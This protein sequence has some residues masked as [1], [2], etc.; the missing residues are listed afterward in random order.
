[1]FTRIQEAGWRQV[2]LWTAVF[3]LSGFFLVTGIG[4]AIGMEDSSTAVK[5]SY[6]AGVVASGL[7]IL[8]G[9]AATSRRPMFGASL[10]VIGTVA[11]VAL[12]W[13]FL[14][15]PP[16][17]GLVVVV[18]GLKRARM[19]RRSAAN[20]PGPTPDSGLSA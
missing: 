12:M 15:I 17:I 10:I 14:F 16:V 1:M 5:V 2:S 13:W 8:T 3:V 7:L 4:I 19:F 20:A 9:F 18:F 6:G 11:G